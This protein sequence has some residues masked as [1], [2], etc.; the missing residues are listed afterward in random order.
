MPTIN[1]T[2][3]HDLVEPVVWLDLIKLEKSWRKTDG[4]VGPGGAGS[5]HRLRYEAVGD[6]IRSTSELH[7]PHLN[8]EQD[9]PVFTD[10]RHRTAWLRDHGA[11]AVPVTT[12][13]AEARRLGELFG[14]DLDVTSYR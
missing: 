4:Y 6:F 13:P 3:V 9:S 12:S 11:H 2:F 14:T 1:W 8:L 7:Y 5:E 10:G